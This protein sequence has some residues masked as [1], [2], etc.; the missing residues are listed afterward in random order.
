MRETAYKCVP[1]VRSN[2]CSFNWK[3]DKAAGSDPHASD[4]KHDNRNTCIRLSLPFHLANFKPF[5]L[6]KKIE[7]K[8]VS[9]AN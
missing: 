8:K 4:S 7:E 5:Y 2:L 1:L 6:I 3:R 9:L